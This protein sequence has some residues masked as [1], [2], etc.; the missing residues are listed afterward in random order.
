MFLVFYD[1]IAAQTTAA[2]IANVI[3]FLHSCITDHG[4]FPGDVEIERSVR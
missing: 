3:E 1:A 2:I 4:F